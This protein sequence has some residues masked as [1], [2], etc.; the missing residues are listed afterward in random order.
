MS[1]V[2]GVV[3]TLGIHFTDLST[4]YE[5]CCPQVHRA[6]IEMRRLRDGMS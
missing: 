5:T 6:M 1:Q 3:Y 2:Q 4:P